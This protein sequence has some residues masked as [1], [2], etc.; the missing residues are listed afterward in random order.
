MLY[1]RRYFGLCQTEIFYCRHKEFISLPLGRVFES[2]KRNGL[3]EV[4]A[5]GASMKALGFL[6]LL[7]GWVISLTAVVLLRMAPQRAGFVLAGIGVEALGL[8]LVAR[9]HQFRR[10]ADE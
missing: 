9:A 6:L 8:I 4:D 1:H 2:N 7:A 3:D 10:R 5:G